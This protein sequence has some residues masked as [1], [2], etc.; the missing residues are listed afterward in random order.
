MN[1]KE[2]MLRAARGE[3]ADRLPFAPRLDLWHNANVRRR[4][5]PARP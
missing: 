2:R 3:W 1:D 5:L 4:T